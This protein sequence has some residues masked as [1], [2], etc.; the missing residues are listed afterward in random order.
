MLSP[1]ALLP[2]GTDSARRRHAAHGQP[3]AVCDTTTVTAD[4]ATVRDLQLITENRDLRQQVKAVANWTRLLAD[5]ERL[6]ARLDDADHALTA[7]LRQ[8]VIRHEAVDRIHRHLFSTR[9]GIAA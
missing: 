8:P 6:T 1:N 9:K 4:A 3:C 5:N 7:L 2:C